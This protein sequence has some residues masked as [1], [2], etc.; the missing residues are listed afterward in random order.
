MNSVDRKQ[1]FFIEENKKK[2][3]EK[4]K[5]KEREKEGE[6]EERNGKERTNL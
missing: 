3:R 1:P 4:G 2:N 5:W 6:E